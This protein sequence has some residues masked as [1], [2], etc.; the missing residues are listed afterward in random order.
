MRLRKAVILAIVVLLGGVGCAKRST[1]TVGGD[2]S[3]REG[4]VVEGKLRDKSL[5]SNGYQYGYRVQLYA[6]RD[7][8]KARN[9]AESARRLFGEKTY[10][11]YQEPLYKV[12]VGD[13][14]LRDQAEG[15]RHRVASSGFEDAWIVETTI[16]TSGIQEKGEAH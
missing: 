15:M 6:T 7:V 9:V 14:L 12:R 8:E 1:T 3:Y 5:E 4:R 11:E 16:R 10:I 2:S 13:Y